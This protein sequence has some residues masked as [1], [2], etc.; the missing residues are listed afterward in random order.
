MRHGRGAAVALVALSLV[1]GGCSGGSAVSAQSSGSAADSSPPPSSSDAADDGYTLAKPVALAYVHALGLGKHAAGKA[2]A[3][4]P[5]KASARTLTLLSRWLEKIPIGRIDAVA[6]ELPSPS[7]TAYPEGSVSVGLA[8][9]ARL[10]RGAL[11]DWV[12]LGDRTL[13]MAERG[14]SWKVVADATHDPAFAVHPSGLALFKHPHFLTGSRVT[15][16]YGLDSARSMADDI[17][18]AADASVPRLAAT[19]GGGPAAARPLIFLVKDRDQGEQLIGYSI[20]QS[21]PLGTVSRGFVYVFLQQYQPIDDVGKSSSVVALMTLLASRI[22]LEHS[23][24]SLQDGV[25]SYEEDAY[26]GG[27]GYILPL[28]QVT[29]AYPGYPSLQRWTSTDSL[30]GLE[31]S[32]QQLASQDALAITH[33]VLEKHGGVGGL[34]RLGKAFAAQG[35]TLTPAKV[36]KAFMKGLH[37]SFDSVLAEAHAYAASGDWKFH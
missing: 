29:A 35:G 23:P 16:V 2:L 28:E 5:D 30:W 6:T 15:V 13:V 14:G 33:V 1:A 10:S 4:P 24:T 19:Y 7:S 20:G 36:R 37:V 21:A 34:R 11:T 12:P 9:R 31:G 27:R 22:M 18:A 17:L 8:V 26:L 32:A 3:A 25:A